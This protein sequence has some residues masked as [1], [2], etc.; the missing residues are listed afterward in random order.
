MNEKWR[1]VLLTVAVF[2]VVLAVGSIYI[3]QN[4]VLGYTDSALLFLAAV[5]AAG[6]FWIGVHI[7]KK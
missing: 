7:H 3:V 4:T 6:C 5:I 2:I 1:A